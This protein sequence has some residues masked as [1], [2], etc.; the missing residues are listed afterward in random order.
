MRHARHNAFDERRYLVRSGVVV[1]RDE[2]WNDIVGEF[3]YSGKDN[4]QR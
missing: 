4:E 2:F 1:E 3:L